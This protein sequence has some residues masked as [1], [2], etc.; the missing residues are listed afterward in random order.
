MIYIYIGFLIILYIKLL[1]DSLNHHIENKKIILKIFSKN[2]KFLNSFF[3]FNIYE[4]CFLIIF[5]RN[6]IN[7][8][9]DN[10][11][12]YK[13]KHIVH[14]ILSILTIIIS[15]FLCYLYT[16]IYHSKRDSFVDILIKYCII[17]FQNVL[18]FVKL[19]IIFFIILVRVYDLKKFIYFFNF[20]CSIVLF[21]YIY[22]E[23]YFNYKNINVKIFYYFS[24]VNLFSSLFLL[25]VNLIIIKN[26][27]YYLILL[28]VLIFFII[29]L[30]QKSKLNVLFFNNNN[31][32]EIFNQTNILIETLN[33]KSERE[34]LLLLI[35]FISNNKDLNSLFNYGEIYKENL[36]ENKM[37]F[38]INEYLEK[39]YKYYINY[40][41]NSV[42]L[43]LAYFKFLKSKLKRFISSYQIIFSLYFEDKNISYFQNYYVYHLKR[44]LEEK[45]FFSKKNKNEETIIS[46]KYQINKIFA[47]LNK[48]SET[49]R[50]LWY[51]ILNTNV[52]YDLTKLIYNGNKILNYL[53]EIFFIM[54]KFNDFKLYNKKVYELFRLFLKNIL[55][56]EEKLSF[57]V[58]DEKFLEENKLKETLINYL[59]I[60]NDIQTTNDFFFILISLQKDSFERIIKISL[61]IC[62]LLG[63]NQEQ[64]I[65][66]K[67][68]KLIPD[69]LK[70]IHK[71][72]LKIKFKQYFETKIETVK[73][74]DHFMFAKTKLKFIIPFPLKIAIIFNENYEKFILCKMDL[75]QKLN[76]E[77]LLKHCTILTDEN[78][79]I[80]TFTSNSLN[81]LNINKSFLNSNYNIK[82]YIFEMQQ[83]YFSHSSFSNI[84]K[85]KLLKK[86]IEK[87]YLNK[88]KNII[89]KINGQN[90]KFKLNTKSIIYLKELKGYIFNFKLIDDKNINKLKSNFKKN[91]EDSLIQN[92]IIK[93][94]IEEDQIENPERKN[95]SN[96]FLFDNK[97]HLIINKNFIPKDKNNIIFNID[98]K[99]Y[100]FSK[101]NDNN[102]DIDF[103][104]K[105]KYYLKN[106]LLSEE[107]NSKTG[108]S[109]F[110]S[111]NLSDS[112][113]YS[114]SSKSISSAE[115]I[116]KNKNTTIQK[117]NE[118]ITYYKPN[119]KNIKFFL[120]NFETNILIDYSFLK[121]NY[122]IEEI[123]EKEKK[124]SEIIIN[125][126]K[127]TPI[128]KE[129]KKQI[130][131]EL[132][133]PEIKRL[134]KINLIKNKEFLNSKIQ[135]KK[136][137]KKI[138][139]YLLI[140]LI[141]II[142]S[143][144][145][146]NFYFNRANKANQ[147]FYSNSYIIKNFVDLIENAQTAYNYAFQIILF[148]N[149]KYKIFKKREKY[150][151]YYNDELLDIY[152]SI[153]NLKNSIVNSDL[154]I[155]THLNNK[156]N[157]ITLK[158][159]V[160]GNNFTKYYEINSTLL[161]ILNE[162]SYALFN[163][164][165]TNESDL[166]FFNSDYNFIF[167]NTFSFFS[168]QIKSYP[169][170]Y[171]EIFIDNIKIVNKQLSI[172][173]IYF[174][175]F[176]IIFICL[177]IYSI[178]KIYKEKY[179]N[180][181]YFFKI[182]K[183]DVSNLLIK[184]DKFLNLNQ[185]VYKNIDFIK[186]PK[187]NIDEEEDKTNNRDDE[188]KKYFLKNKQEKEIIQTN[189]KINIKGIIINSII[190]IIFFF[191]Y[192]FILFYLKFYLD[193]IFN[194]IFHYIIIYYLTILH[195]LLFTTYYNYI[196]LDIVYNEYLNSFS[197]LQLVNL[198]I[199]MYLGD[200]FQTNSLYNNLIYGN[201]TKY[202]LPKKSYNKYM[203]F[204]T[205][206]L[207]EYINEIE[208]NNTD[209]D[210]IG[211]NILSY[212]MDSLQNYFFQNILIISAQFDIL[213]LIDNLFNFEYNEIFY[214]TEEYNK[215]KNNNSLYEIF[216]PFNLLNVEA[217]KT[218]TII[219]NDILKNAYNDLST[220][221]INDILNIFDNIEKMILY[222]QVIFITYLCFIIFLYFFYDIFSKNNEINI[223]R[224][225]LQIIPKNIF[226]EIINEEIYY[227]ELK[228]LNNK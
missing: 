206:N 72:K 121:N 222:L 171:L 207:C 117:F 16:N 80:K 146:F 151:I 48:A 24:L 28:M 47:L 155:S 95:K 223:S 218:L 11:T 15:T 102:N 137:N 204:N 52:N 154:H 66:H 3:L 191:F 201:I 74:F 1:I 9:N 113:Y 115:L 161:N 122:K 123:I 228:N 56:D 163:F 184:C 36:S 68:Y 7:I 89:W 4:L 31:E 63:Y 75:S 226:F 42:L 71:K 69:F 192:L 57:Y 220:Y 76:F 213:I 149:E 5:C 13:G 124:Y 132:L 187:I 84:N 59:D 208:L 170:I 211:N 212:G 50:N 195:K 81:L 178:Y 2:L 159:V 100:Y 174:V 83:D 129:F 214:G 97:F 35:S 62:K 96:N 79:F 58:N 105:N 217:M 182:K 210:S 144:I 14:F 183:I 199:H 20:F 143:S 153:L 186:S 44:N 136:I 185:I 86:I 141:S 73:F 131:K 172:F 22:K 158:E 110:L 98:E 193:D 45:I 23:H 127:S 108:S 41:N 189:L 82:N 135:P 130:G 168:E 53:D 160:V 25:L 12:C 150:I 64:L 60:E 17:N 104:F 133:L 198:A 111:N 176:E 225:M 118:N 40:Y 126:I 90:I 164:I 116:K 197:L 134:E 156:I 88:E 37:N 33:K 93:S 209:C 61:D 55:N 203:D 101:D 54:K 34:N 180:F 162:Y 200:I 179:K 140:I 114:S 106:D 196:R 65:N 128:N 94:I 77:K 19:F 139:Y 78:L 39:I 224:K 91:T 26:L 221:I 138:I 157:D 125:K 32:Y 165:Y 30:S 46:Y 147:N 175:I 18:I 99:T 10:F 92:K 43:K 194:K 27:I 103:Y 21:Y 167:F 107:K 219:N 190:N 148:K 67:I 188:I 49:Y 87:Y 177:K 166:N 145:V 6:K 215:L 119:L 205:K 38:Y 8:F 202:G 112:S 29:F 109:S 142:N 120:Y 152:N 181:K 169:N 216:N 227:K 70:E 51:Y 173:I 85:E